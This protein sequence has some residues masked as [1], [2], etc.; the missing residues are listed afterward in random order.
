MAST[1]DVS[2]SKQEEG[3]GS[4]FRLDREIAR[5]YDPATLSRFIV[6]DA[7]RGEP[8]D[9]HTRS[10]MEQRLGGDFSNVRIIRGPLA[11]EVTARYSADAVQ[12]G[13][14]ELIL[15]REGWQS[16]FQSAEGAALLAH[17][18][19]HVRQ[20]QQ[21]LHFEHSGGDNENSEHEVEAYTVQRLVK[22]AE[23]GQHLMQEAAQRQ[24]LAARQLWKMV[25]KTA[26]E[27]HKKKEQLDG[28]RGGGANAQSQHR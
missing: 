12:V 2:G 19:T 28:I 26:K 14:T 10:R 4:D 6:R 24:E 11:E 17:E 20:S 18:L 23:Q 5:R 8:L 25:L 1:D 9:L 3:D 22:A 15:V 27:L 13:G 7:G 16:N 21:G